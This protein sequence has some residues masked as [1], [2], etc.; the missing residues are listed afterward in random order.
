MGIHPR[1]LFPFYEL[2]LWPGIELKRTIFHFLFSLH[3]INIDVFYFNIHHV[4]YGKGGNTV[5]NE[6]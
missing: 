1:I 6:A 3:G 5:S 2:P 4:C